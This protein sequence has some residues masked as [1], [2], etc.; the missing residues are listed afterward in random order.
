MKLVYV[1][2]SKLPTN[3]AHGLQ[4]MQMCSAFADVGLEVQLIVPARAGTVPQDPFD[5][6]GIKKNFKITKLPCVDFL[7]LSGNKFIFLLQLSSFL[8]ASRLYLFFRRYDFI[9][10]RE[11][12]V[13]LLFRRAIL[14]IHSLPK[15]YGK[16]YISALKSARALIVLTSFIKERMVKSGINAQNI[17]VASDAVNLEKF[18][19]DISKS[20]ARKKLNLPLDKKLV[21]YVGMLR[22]LGMEKGIDVAIDAF[23]AIKDR[24]DVSLVLVGGFPEDIAYYRDAAKTSGISDRVIFT[25]M[26]RHDS[27]PEYL[28][29]FDILIAPFPETEHYNFYMSPLKIFEYMASNRPIISTHLPSLKEVLNPLNSVLVSPGSAREL[30]MAILDI[31]DD[32]NFSK[33]IAGQ[34]LR[35][36]HGY[37]WIK[38]AERI[39]DFFKNLS[40]NQDAERLNIESFSSP[41]SVREYSKKYLRAGE[42]YVIEKYMPADSSV[43]D[44]GCGAGRTTIYIFENG[45]NVI[46][47]DISDSLIDQARKNFPEIDF[48]VMDA[49]SL[50]FKDSSFDAVFFSFNGIDNLTSLTERKKVMEEVRRVLRPGGFFIYS[51]HNSLAFPRTATSWKILF[52]NFGRLRFGPHWRNEEYDFGKLVQYYNNIWNERHSL[53][54]VGFRSV[55]ALGNSGKLLKAPDFILAFLDKFPIYIAQK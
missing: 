52:N 39:S 35:D 16:F 55:T 54:S 7:H 43:L 28:K 47:V 50:N 30:G 17:L 38:R 48:R 18:N 5:Y 25:G 32:E 21:G 33:K 26:V 12:V 13:S 14:E 23:S 4:V 19:I 8:A 37:T 51:S 42:K 34:A 3:S 1:S 45:C 49:R 46:G 9:Y 24:A 29:A 22:T 53:F 41:L 2:N 15:N 31:L 10:S 27:V 6:Y 44:L 36:V 20:D 40:D 11:S